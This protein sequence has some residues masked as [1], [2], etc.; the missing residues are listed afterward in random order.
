MT[1]EERAKMLG[2]IPEHKDEN[3]RKDIPEEKKEKPE[4][5]SDKT[6]YPDRSEIQTEEPMVSDPRIVNELPLVLDYRNFATP[7]RHQKQCGSCWAFATIATLEAQIRRQ[8]PQIKDIDLSEQ[9]LISCEGSCR[10]YT[11]PYALDFLKHS[12]TPLENCAPYKADDN[13]QYCST[14]C[15]EAELIKIKD[16]KFFQ[17]LVDLPIVNDAKYS[18]HKP[19][20]KWI[21]GVQKALAEN[22][23]LVTYLKVQADFFF[24]GKGIYRSVSPQMIGYHGVS[25]FGYNETE[26]F[27]IIKNSWGIDWGM[28]GYGY[29]SWDDDYSDFGKQLYAVY[30]DNA[31]P[32]PNPDEFFPSKISFLPETKK[33]FSNLVVDVSKNCDNKEAINHIQPLTVKAV[34]HDLRGKVI[35]SPDVLAGISAYLYVNNTQAVVLKESN[36]QIE[37]EFRW[38]NLPI[39]DTTSF[40]LKGEWRPSEPSGQAVSRG[41]T[42]DELMVR[43]IYKMRNTDQFEQAIVASLKVKGPDLVGDFDLN[44]NQYVEIVEGCGGSEFVMR[45]SRDK[46]TRLSEPMLSPSRL[47]LERNKQLHS[48]GI[49]FSGINPE[50]VLNVDETW[51]LTVTASD[52][53]QKIRPLTIPLRI[54][55]SFSIVD[56]FQPYIYPAVVVLIIFLLVIFLRRMILVDKQN[57]WS[58]RIAGKSPED[59]WGKRDIFAPKTSKLIASRKLFIEITQDAANDPRFKEFIRA[60]RW[61]HLVALEKLCCNP[62]DISMTY[63]LSGEAIGLSSFQQGDRVL[64]SRRQELSDGFARIETCIEPPSANFYPQRG[65]FRDSNGNYLPLT[66]PV[67]VYDHLS[68]TVGQDQTPSAKIDIALGAKEIIIEVSGL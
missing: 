15:S 60:Q 27:W 7:I 53:S 59:F 29:L 48:I 21:K 56:R 38:G 4:A 5:D 17:D 31:K 41:L 1:P 2:T 63:S 23:P 51:Q 36:G 13:K 35:S 46:P 14:T 25:L 8:N 55:Y 22:G 54:T 20:E 68:I 43:Q 33:N 50:R 67:P 61:K 65:F 45:V 12:G 49:A 42:G 19:S 11:I 9:Y 30:L 64:R 6:Q 66:K 58:D 28:D 37:G 44:L 26:R 52:T 24:Y 57:F 16:Y 10:G 3:E 32:V 34:V 62:S 18:R 47:I 39:R 40:D